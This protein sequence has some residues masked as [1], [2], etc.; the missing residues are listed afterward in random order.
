MLPAK[1]SKTTPQAQEKIVLISA[2]H[3]HVMKKTHDDRLCQLSCV[4]DSI[5]HFS[6]RALPKFYFEQLGM[7][8]V[9]YQRH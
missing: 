1:K 8:N 5:V 9:R 6:H 4:F 2:Y 7:D 3:A